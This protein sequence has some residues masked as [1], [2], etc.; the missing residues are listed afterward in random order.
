MINLKKLI[1]KYKYKF[2]LVLFFI[3]I[4]SLIN[5][6]L[7]YII[8][9]TIELTNNNVTFS[10]IKFKLMLLVSIY[11]VITLICSILEFLKSTLLAKNT[12]NFI[13]DIRKTAYKRIMTF[14]MD[15][16]SN[17]H[18]STLVTRMTSDISNIG[19]FIGRFLPMFISSGIFL[20]VI[21]VVIC[22]INIYFALIMVICSLFL[23]I[24]IL[25]IGKKM[26][27]YK[28]K[29]IEVTENLNNFFG[30]TF[31]G[32]KTLHIFNIQKE[33][34]KIYDEYNKTELKMATK[35]FD[36][37]SFLTP[38]KSTTR[39]FIVFLILYLC[40]QGKVAN[41]NIGII[42]LVISYIDKFF[43]PLGNML[44]HYEDLQKGKI[45]MK[46]IDELLGKEENIENIYSGN[47][48]EKL[49]GNIKFTNVNF[50]YVGDKK[51][52]ENVNFSINKGEKIA[53]IGETGSGKT[54]IINLILGF[55]KIDYGNIMFDGKNIDDIS[56]ESLRKNISFIQQNPYIFN[57]TI[58]KN[59]IVNNENNISDKKIIEILKLVGLYNKVKSFN[60]EIN[61]YVN[62]NSFS[63]GEKQLLAFA[64]AIAKETS[65][66][67][68]DE[69]TSNIDIEN[70]KKI[71]KI[72][73]NISKNSTIIIIA[74]RPTTIE[75]VDR[76]FKVENKKVI[77]CNKL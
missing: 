67:I 38:V 45:S 24:S 16:F 61:E 52:L 64:R 33:R 17:M 74:H 34:K 35:Y 46:R 25:K 18:I 50:S 65:I 5:T 56:L 58:R 54:T 7:P 10:D 27:G 6:L 28:K 73:N 69:P 19:E 55:Y 63:K 77:I 49:Y 76:I 39:Y 30:E 22:F 20:I 9:Q 66:Y 53:L 12:Q 36:A 23:V 3:I 72:I 2:V 71:T 41:V 1:F 44:Y 59:I 15:T 60:N 4:I 48:A 14:N 11:M 8:K 43:E 21:L 40:L 13:Y 75:N 32:I 26:A 47:P 29:E 68:F 70:E 42:Y 37:Q 51:I 31:S 57:D 62:E